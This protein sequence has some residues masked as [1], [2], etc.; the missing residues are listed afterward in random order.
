M[1]LTARNLNLIEFVD[2]DGNVVPDG[3]TL[4]LTEVTAEEDPFFGDITYYVYSHLKVRNK[5]AAEQAMC[6]NM[7]INRIDNGIYQL[8]FPMNCNSYSQACSVVT[9]GCDLAANELRDLQTEWIPTAEGGC[10]VVMKVEI[11]RRTGTFPN[12][13]YTYVEDGPTVTLHY[14]NGISD[15]V[16]GDI[17][18][19]GAVDIADVNAVINM[20]LGKV[21][22]VDAADVTQDGA[23]DI[24]DVNAVINLMLGK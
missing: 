20:M 14:R 23:I 18:G 10:D 6:I 12:F 1:T 9:D 2:K 7:T 11:M 21:E 24:A 3:T 13:N 22:A 4:T 17:T 19:D 16:T 8:C 5:T 15:P